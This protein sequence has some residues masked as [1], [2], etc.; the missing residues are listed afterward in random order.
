MFKSQKLKAVLSAATAFVLIASI[1]AVSLIIASAAPVLPPGV[2]PTE[3]YIG[4]SDSDYLP[5]PTNYDMAQKAGNL[6]EKMEKALTAAKKA[7]KIDEKTYPV[8]NYSYYPDISGEI[9]SWYFTWSS[10]DSGKNINIS[11]SGNGKVISYGKYEYNEQTQRKYIKLAEISKP[12]AKSN[13][14]DFLR[15]VLGDEFKNYKLSNQYLGGLYLGFPSDRYIL[16]Y[17]LNKN[18]YD[19]TEFSINVEI[20]KITGE[21]LR[22]SRYDYNRLYDT[23]EN[24]F[25]YQDASKVITKEEAL[26]SYLDKIG[27]ELVYTSQFDWQTKKLTVKPVYRLSNNYSDYISAVNGELITINNEFGAVPTNEAIAESSA[28]AMKYGVAADSA[29]VVSFT[30]AEIKEIENLKNYITADK[31]IEIMIKAFGLEL[32][33]I[34]EYYKNT[35]LNVD[36]INQKQYCWS[37]YLYKDSENLYENY[38][39]TIDAR[40]GNI[41]SYSNYSRS[42]V[43]Y[44]YGSKTKTEPE[45]IYTYEQAKKIVIEKIKE[46]SPYDI[47]KNFELVENR[48]VAQEKQIAKVNSAGGKD[49]LASKENK[50]AYYYFNF[51]RTVNGIKFDSNSLNVNF[52]NTTGKIT[53]YNISWYENAKF[54]KLTNIIS[55][56]KALERIADFADYKIYYASNGI[57]D[58]GKINAVLIYMFDNS[59]MVDPFTG[60]WLDWNFEELKK[61]EPQPDYKDLDGHKDEKIIK[62]L[63][64]NGIYVWGGEAFEPEKYITKGELLDYLKFYTY[65]YYY[66]A[67][68]PSS[69][70]VN[71][72]AYFRDI[73]NAQDKDSDKILT[74]QEAAKIICELAGYGELGKH[75]EVFVYPFNDGKCDEQYKGYI[76]ILKVFGLISGDE[77][78]NFNATENLTRAGAAE[79]VYNIIMAY[80]K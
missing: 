41:I 54:P 30:E 57:T 58:D 77:K 25:N 49:G 46:L 13:A 60:D 65:N 27:L 19:Y 3:N 76:A 31:A 43:Y 4:V 14:N 64:D 78:G 52:D 35:N 37:I 7:I 1:M 20:D 62:I 70:F 74:K 75:S 50:D 18:G 61:P 73:N 9:E 36:Y 44:D 17:V 12:K 53:F 6:D 11:V 67:E 42:P 80:N 55:P 72:Y 68:I 71:S 66:F 39:A 40:N 33:D 34:S 21:V 45:Y 47:D 69:I 32:G 10:T 15:K 8:F 29:G 56:E 79:I 51:I 2:D 63:A 59:V 28:R 16:T 5:A 38:S 24:N 23:N 48:T 26:K 22:F